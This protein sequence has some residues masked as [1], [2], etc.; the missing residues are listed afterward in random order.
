MVP[1]PNASPDKSPTYDLISDAN[2]AADLRDAS[3]VE[4]NLDDADAIDLQALADEAANATPEFMA[5]GDDGEDD[6]NAAIDS[7]LLDPEMPAATATAEDYE[8]QLARLHIQVGELENRET[9]VLD[10]YKRLK[11][12]YLNYRDRSA[13]D[14]QVALNQADRKVLMEILPVL[15]NFERSLGA[16]YPDMDAFR[17]GVEL[18]HKQFVDAL[19]RI[20]AEPVTLNVGDPFDA[21]HSEAL[22]TISNVNLPDGAIAAI[23]ER[24]YMLRDQLL[25]PARVVVNHNPDAETNPGDD[26]GRVP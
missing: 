17:I 25:R 26:A 1:E 10:H 18:I 24:G 9:D 20:G 19:R 2:D 7:I 11:A 12:E 22:T 4:L 3:T 5:A 16:S 23:Y 13:R 15:D 6:E 21:L 8:R 14:T